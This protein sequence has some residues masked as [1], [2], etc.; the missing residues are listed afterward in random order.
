MNIL[1]IALNPN[2]VHTEGDNPVQG[3]STETNKYGHAQKR[4]PQK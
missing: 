2:R 1:E 3:Y 4:P